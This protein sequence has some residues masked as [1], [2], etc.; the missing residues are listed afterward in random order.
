MGR[1]KL[2]S[3]SAECGIK[4]TIRITIKITIRITIKI[5]IKIDSDCR[6][7]LIHEF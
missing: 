5:T 7:A 2:H 3:R 1:E 4:I 6:L